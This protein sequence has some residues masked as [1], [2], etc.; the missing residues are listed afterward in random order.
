MLFQIRTIPQPK[1]MI[2]ISEFLKV[3]YIFLVIV[4]ISRLFYLDHVQQT[5]YKV[6]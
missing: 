1:T 3:F 4:Q 6:L 2:E 5:V